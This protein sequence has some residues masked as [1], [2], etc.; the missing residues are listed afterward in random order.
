MNTCFCNAKLDGND[1]HT[2]AVYDEHTQRYFCSEGCF[3][4]WA[5]AN[6]D[7]VVAF[8]ERMNVH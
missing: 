7:E 6:F 4:D 2:D 8:Y 5:D 3:R 1:P